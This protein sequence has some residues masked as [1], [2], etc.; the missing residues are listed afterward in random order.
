M[1]FQ[2]QLARERREWI[3]LTGSLIALLLVGFRLWTSFCFF[4][5][6]EWNSIRLAPSFMLHPGA[7]PYPGL[8]GGPLTT[9]IYGPVPLLLNLPATLAHDTVTALLV[10]GTINLLIAVIP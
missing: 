10:A 1:P 8:G 9:W 2:V 5:L 6:P 7:T 4:P 3:V